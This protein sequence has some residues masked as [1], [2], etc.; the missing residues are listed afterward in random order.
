MLVGSK[1]KAM[2]KI[3]ASAHFN[4]SF[5]LD[6]K[7]ESFLKKHKL[8]NDIE[9]GESKNGRTAKLKPEKA[10]ELRRVSEL[11]IHD[12][13]HIE[14]REAEVIN[15]VTKDIKEKF[16]AEHKGVPDELKVIVSIDSSD[17]GDDEHQ[18]VLVELQLGGQSEEATL[19]SLN[20]NG[21]FNEIVGD[22]AGSYPWAAWLGGSEDSP[23]Y[24]EAFVEGYGRDW[25]S[26]AVEQFFHTRNETEYFDE[27]KGLIDSLMKD[28]TPEYTYIVD[29]DERGEYRAHVEDPAGNSV[30]EIKS[31]PEGIVHPIEDGYMKN[32]RDMK[33]LTKYLKQL[34]IIPET[35]DEIKY[36]G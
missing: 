25:M 11:F 7:T 3:L 14:E 26:I 20:V 17:V 32:G 22:A 30:Y 31:D 15:G 23:F 16:A 24:D 18:E 35:A 8:M 28:Y 19:D 21:N 34:E 6:K 12:N 2:W 33:G 5:D 27:I 9:I 1:Y 29:M 13:K 10:E 36:G 4:S